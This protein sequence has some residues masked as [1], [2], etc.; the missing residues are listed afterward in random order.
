M[1]TKIT[2]SLP[3]SAAQLADAITR[4]IYQDTAKDQR[5]RI[6]EAYGVF[7]HMADATAFTTSCLFRVSAKQV[8][9]WK[10]VSITIRETS[11]RDLVATRTFRGKDTAK[12]I[13]EATDWAVAQ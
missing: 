10:E 2:Q 1:T 6:D 7:S 4:R 9:Q 3:Q 12:L 13:Q 5:V 8:A 11:T